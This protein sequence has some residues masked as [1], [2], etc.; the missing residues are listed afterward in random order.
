MKFI[1]FAISLLLG[2]AVAANA[3]SDCPSSD[4]VN[5]EGVKTRTVDRVRDPN[6]PS[7]CI[8]KLDDSQT[9][10]KDGKCECY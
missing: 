2:A 9:E 7:Q 4:E 8:L 3:D 6:D 5:T 10:K 1:T